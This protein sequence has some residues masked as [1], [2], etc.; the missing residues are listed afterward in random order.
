MPKTPPSGRLARTARLGG[1]VAG[2]S[3][4]WAGTQAANLV[5]SEERADAATGE[6]A[7]ALAHRLAAPDEVDL[8]MP[9]EGLDDLVQ[10]FAAPRDIDAVGLAWCLQL[11]HQRP[12]LATRLKSS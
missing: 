11:G 9:A 7:G 3:A 4:R 12:L 8:G 5:R 1:L 10:A 2:Q 6:R